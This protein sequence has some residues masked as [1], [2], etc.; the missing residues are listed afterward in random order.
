MPD[1]ET[2][3]EVTCVN[4]CA[5]FKNVVRQYRHY[6]KKTYFTGKETHE[7]PLLSPETHLRDDDCEHLVLYWSRPKNRN[8]CLNLKDNCCQDPIETSMTQQNADRILEKSTPLCNGKGSNADKVQDSET[9]L[10]VSNKADKTDKENYLED[11]E[12]TP[13]SCIDV[14]FELLATTAGTSSLNL[15]PESVRLLE[16]QLQDERHRSAVLRQEAE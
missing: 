16:S 10:L 5:I 15:L 8:K 6:A 14:V 9:T 13:R 7:I 2:Q 3:D 12:T 11:S 1:L 4:T